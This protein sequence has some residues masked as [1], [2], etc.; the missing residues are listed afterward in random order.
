MANIALIGATGNIGARVLDEALARGHRVTAFS[1][2]PTRIAARKGMTTRKGN[3][4]E[5]ATLAATLA[6]HDAVV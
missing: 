1:R 2:D 3:I 6:G 4:A 5:V